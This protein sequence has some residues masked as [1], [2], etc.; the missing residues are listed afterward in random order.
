MVFHRRD[1]RLEAYSPALEASGFV[2]EAIRRSPRKVSDRTGLA[3]GAH[4]MVSAC[5]RAHKPA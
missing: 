2:I 4:P 3:G 1:R 5:V